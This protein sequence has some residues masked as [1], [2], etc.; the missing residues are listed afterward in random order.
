MVLYRGQLRVVAGV[1]PYNQ[2][3]KYHVV[4]N[5][6]TDMAREEELTRYEEEK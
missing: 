2:L 3:N 4:R 6:S 5:G 1:L